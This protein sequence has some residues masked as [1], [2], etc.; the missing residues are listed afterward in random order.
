MRPASFFIN[1]LRHW[2]R[3]GDCKKGNAVDF[4]STRKSHGRGGV[5]LLRAAHLVIEALG[6][7]AAE[8]ATRRAAELEF[9]G[10]P[11]AASVWRRLVPIV[12][13]L[14]HGRDIP[15]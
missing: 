5:S 9:G 7:D 14:L 12:E 4:H 10:D 3:I 13:E 2:A 11:M 6:E 1:C 15:S 8:Y